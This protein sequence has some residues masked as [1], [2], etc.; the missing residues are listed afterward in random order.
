MRIMLQVNQQL[1]TGATSAAS[2]S[3]QLEQVVNELRQ[4]VGK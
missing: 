1:V 3:T 2:A 4:V